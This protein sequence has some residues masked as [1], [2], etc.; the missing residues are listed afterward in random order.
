LPAVL[1]GNRSGMVLGEG[2]AMLVLEPWDRAQ[3]RGA[4][5]LGEVLG[6]G[7]SNDASHIT[8]PQVQGQA[9]A[10]RAALQ[11]AGLDAL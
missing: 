6:Y 1:E 7:L 3:A 2:A 4:P 5:I 10:M 9:S 11:S 8:R